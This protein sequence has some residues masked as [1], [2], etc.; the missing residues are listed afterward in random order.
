METDEYKAV[1][2][3]PERPEEPQQ[4]GTEADTTEEYRFT[5]WA[6]I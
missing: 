6:L 1:E 4:D 5:D 3:Q 2:D